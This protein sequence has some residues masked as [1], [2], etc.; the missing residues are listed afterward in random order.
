MPPGSYSH[1][2]YQQLIDQL[3]IDVGDPS[4]IFFT[5]P[6]LEQ[7]LRETLG[8]WNQLTG[9]YRTETHFPTVAGTA[10]YDLQL[11]SQFSATLAPTITDRELLGRM[12]YRLM[13]YFDPIN[14]TNPTEMF[15][16]A[17][18]T[19]VLQQ[20]R[21][22]FI[23][24]TANTGT[25]RTPVLVPVSSNGVYLLPD[26]VI[27]IQRA[28][29]ITPDN[30]FY[31]ITAPTD[32]G[33]AISTLPA[34]NLTPGIPIT[35]SLALKP[36][37][38]I[39]LIPPPNDDGYLVLF[40]NDTG[41]PLDPTVPTVT[42]ISDDLAA[43]VL[44]GAMSDLLLKDGIA[45]DPARAQ[46]CSDL[47]DMYVQ[48]AIDLPTILGISMIN[49]QMVEPCHI[50]MLDSMRSGWEGRNHD[51]PTTPTVMARW[52]ILQPIPDDV[53]DIGVMY[54]QNA[55]IPATTDYI[56]LSREQLAAVRS[57]AKQLL[58]FK[59]QGS[60]LQTAQTS[61]QSLIEQARTY[62]EY[63]IS[64][65]TYLIEMLGREQN[66]TSTPIRRNEPG[67]AN[68]DNDPSDKSTES[69]SARNPRKR[70][71]GR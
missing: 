32:E 28:V 46:F 55:P 11:L 43:G 33:V 24:E 56:Q 62:N 5:E 71:G 58:M 17:E 49:G 64:K 4:K 51:I 12:Q 40:T 59:K 6:E 69:S 9:Y 18:M 42:G 19:R 14:G 67:I 70:L 23:S 63:R 39:Q 35:W 53:Y 8:L 7:C 25:F 21:D 27:E 68:L 48:L 29:W 57:W 50:S 15:T 20:R 36:N 10:W 34:W 60:Q 66:R 26:T 65:S 44:W 13:E 47:Y 38:A 45:R 16:L 22:R 54:L 37:L 30:H 52:I 61:A 31:T 3:S 1:T 2:T 41:V